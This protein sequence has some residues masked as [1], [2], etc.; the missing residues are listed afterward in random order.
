MVAWLPKIGLGL[1]RLVTII[2][3]VLGW[4]INVFTLWGQAKILWQRL[5]KKS[6]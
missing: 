2:P 1:L 6:S 4:L 5:R 3:K